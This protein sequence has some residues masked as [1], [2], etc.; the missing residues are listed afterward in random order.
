MVKIS[1]SSV[2]DNLSQVG[3]NFSRNAISSFEKENILDVSFNLTPKN[4]TYDQRNFTVSIVGTKYD[5]QWKKNS[6]HVA[7]GDKLTLIRDK[8]NKYDPFAIL[9]TYNERILGYIPRENAKYMAT[10]MDL[11]N[12]KYEAIVLSMSYVQ[13]EDYNIINISVNVSFF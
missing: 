8:E 5:E 12:T 2:W 4:N 3:F 13:N 11:N 1:S 10:E 6:K 9:V 7:I